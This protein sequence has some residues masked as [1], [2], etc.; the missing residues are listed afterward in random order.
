MGWERCGRFVVG[1]VPVNERPVPGMCGSGHRSAVMMVK[2]CG[3]FTVTVVVRRMS[4]DEGPIMRSQSPGS[5][6]GR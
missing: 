5:T 2:A 3:Y 6:V 1:G 4:A